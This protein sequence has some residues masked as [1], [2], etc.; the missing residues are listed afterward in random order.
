MFEHYVMFR[1]KPGKKGELQTFVKKLMQ[2]EKD[3]PVIRFSEV[4]LNGIK[5]PHSFDLMFHVR[6]DDEAAYR[7]YMAHPK[8]LPAMKYVA[9]ICDGIADVDAIR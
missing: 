9:E 2:L 7:A 3:V 6:L 4:L 5:A 1:L 8:H